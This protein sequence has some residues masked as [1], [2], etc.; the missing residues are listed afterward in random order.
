MNKTKTK[1]HKGRYDAKSRRDLNEELKKLR[2]ERETE[3]EERIQQG[4]KD[5][6]RRK[7]AALKVIE[8]MR[9][10]TEVPRRAMEEMTHGQKGEKNG[11]MALLER[12]TQALL[13][14]S[15]LQD[16]AEGWDNEDYF[17]D[18]PDRR[19]PAFMMIMMPIKRTRN[20]NLTIN[21]ISTSDEAKIMLNGP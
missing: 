3:K 17:Q 5:M 13:G 18:H 21:L 1:T 8:A 7:G 4:I 12:F 9:Q 15:L 20:L 19:M 2:E 16:I 6:M 14:Q 11:N 10:N